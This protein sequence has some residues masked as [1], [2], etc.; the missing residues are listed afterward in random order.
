MECVAVLSGWSQFGRRNCPIRRVCSPSR[1]D[2][3]Q[4]V[5]RRYNLDVTVRVGRGSKAHWRS[6]DLKFRIESKGNRDQLTAAFKHIAIGLCDI[7]D[8]DDP[9]PKYVSDPVLLP[10]GLT[11]WVDSPDAP[12]AMID[13]IIATVL[14]GLVEAGIDARISAPVEL[15]SSPPE[16]R[17][18]VVAVPSP[19]GSADQPVEIPSW[20]IDRAVGWVL[21]GNPSLVW[22]GTAASSLALTAEAAVTLLSEWLAT[23]REVYLAAD[24]DGDR[25]GATVNL[26]ASRDSY[27]LPHISLSLCGTSTQEDLD[28]SFER[29]IDEG[30]ALADGSCWVF[31][32]VE[33]EVMTLVPRPEPTWGGE[34]RARDAFVALG[35]GIFDA[36][37]WQLLSTPVAAKLPDA[38]AQFANFDSTRRELRLGTLDDWMRDD[39]WGYRYGTPF[40]RSMRRALGGAL[41]TQDRAWGACRDLGRV[42]WAD[43]KETD[44]DSVPLVGSESPHPTLG[45]SPLQLVSVLRHEPFSD[46]SFGLPGALRGWLRQLA[47]RLPTSELHRLRPIAT[48]IAD[49]VITDDRQVRRTLADWLIR[50]AA[51]DLLD[52]AG[53]GDSETLRRLGSLTE[54]FQPLD[55]CR[56]VLEVLSALQV[57]L[58]QRTPIRNDPNELVLR[59]VRAVE[60]ATERAATELDFASNSQANNK[61]GTAVSSLTRSPMEADNDLARRVWGAGAIEVGTAAFFEADWSARLS[62]PRNASAWSKAIDAVEDVDEWRK[63]C[64]AAVIALMQES[65]AARAWDVAIDAAQAA[66]PEYWRA[67]L[68]SIRDQLGEE[69]LAIGWE[70]GRRRMQEIHLDTRLSAALAAAAVPAA[71]VFEMAAMLAHAEGEDAAIAETLWSDLDLLVAGLTEID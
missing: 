28:R 34:P 3:L 52:V 59:S 33:R 6:G 71:L 64:D 21:A 39:Q 17:V 43:E 44:V 4:F 55:H 42:L 1:W 38:L 27:V 12:D 61:V 46:D 40:R 26:P 48:A 36:S 56:S 18:C 15:P 13:Q 10:D 20:Q 53:V 11:F 23:G 8:E 9:G 62:R 2:G 37:P 5:C 70:A 19:P 45:V 67:R 31:A 51:P 69:A 16:P 68:G 47:E 57:E 63:S 58:A 54:G 7:G 35:E 22:V 65:D 14:D 24:V 41:L 25:R 49:N 32:T 30:R 50:T 60:M 66:A 29:I